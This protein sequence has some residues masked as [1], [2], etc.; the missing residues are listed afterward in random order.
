MSK[1]TEW[2]GQKKW[3]KLRK[4]QWLIL[5]LAGILLLVIALPSSC[6]GEEKEEEAA[7]DAGQTSAA[8]VSAAGR[9]MRNSWNSAWRR[10]FP[11]W[12][13]WGRCGS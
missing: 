2:I 13:A 6:G 1:W 4:D 5:F 3:R 8:S 9:S 12:R 11:A 10:S 7:S